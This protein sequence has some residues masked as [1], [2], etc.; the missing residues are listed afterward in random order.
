MK[1]IVA[2]GR[3]YTLTKDD[4][5]LLTQIGP[6]EIVSGGAKGADAGGEEYAKYMGLPCKRFPADWKAHGKAA[7]PLRNRQMAEYADAVAL[8][9]GG[10]GTNSMRDEARRAGIKI[11][12]YAAMRW[13]NQR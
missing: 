1:L 10:R 9:P 7:G 3:D 4:W 11:F 12:D 5:Q 13:G 8:F 6:S 2:G